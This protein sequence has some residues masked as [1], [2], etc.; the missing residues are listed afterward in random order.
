LAREAGTRRRTVK[1]DFQAE[2]LELRAELDGPD[3]F[4]VLHSLCALEEDWARALLRGRNRGRIATMAR[5]RARAGIDPAVARAAG[6]HLAAAEKCQREVA[7]Y[8]TA[9]AEGLGFFAPVREFQVAQAWLLA[10]RARATGQGV[11]ARRALSVAAEVEGDTN[12]QGL[13][14]AASLRDL[15]AWVRRRK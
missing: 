5:A 13:A 10:A 8:A 7:S 6:S 14:Y 11:E 15:R 1:R 12:G 2:A 4:H 3:R 9:G